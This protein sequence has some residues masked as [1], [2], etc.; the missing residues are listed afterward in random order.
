MNVLVLALGILLADLPGFD[1]RAFARYLQP[2]SGTIEGRLVVQLPDG[3]LATRTNSPVLALPDTAYTKAWLSESAR[4]IG[5]ASPSPRAND[6]PPLPAVL[7]KYARGTHTDGDGYFHF[8]NLP[9]GRYVIRGRLTI[10]FP[11]TVGSEEERQTV[12]DYSYVW[13]VSDAIAVRG[14]MAPDVVFHIVARRN[15]VARTR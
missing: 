15:R 4:T 13:L 7:D 14:S 12:Y 11:R 3:A 8:R 2:G 10:A 9:D 5:S 6:D 1:A